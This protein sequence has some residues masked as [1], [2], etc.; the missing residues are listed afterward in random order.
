MES[1][2]GRSAGGLS[3]AIRFHLRNLQTQVPSSSTSLWSPVRKTGRHTGS[4]R[5]LTLI[6]RVQRPTF[7]ATNHCQHHWNSKRGKRGVSEAREIK[8]ARLNVLDAANR[9]NECK[10][11]PQVA[12]PVLF[13]AHDPN[14][15]IL[16]AQRHPGAMTSLPP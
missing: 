4:H 6:M 2:S 11:I 10:H 5:T 14:R 3:S 9:G 16:S 15:A 13:V 1:C 7:A 12:V 8:M